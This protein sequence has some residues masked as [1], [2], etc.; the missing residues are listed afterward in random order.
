MTS[1]NPFVPPELQPQPNRW[2]R[3]LFPEVPGVPLRER[4][5]WT[6]KIGLRYV[7]DIVFYTPRALVYGL[8]NSEVELLGDHDFEQRFD[9]T[10]FNKMVVS[11]ESER[12]AAF[13]RQQFPTTMTNSAVRY[14][15]ADFSIFETLETFPGTY[16][17]GTTVLFERDRPGARLK[18]VAIRIK[19]MEL[20]PADGDAWE[21]AKLYALQG[22][23]IRLV[24]GTHALLHFPEDSIN[25]IAKVRL[26]TNHILYQLLIP[27]L[28]LQLSLDNTV[29]TSPTSPLIN[30][31]I[32]WWNPHTGPVRSLMRSVKDIYAGVEDNPAYCTYTYKHPRRSE[33]EK[34]L[35]FLEAYYQTILR[36][37]QKVLAKI[38]PGDEHVMRWADE[39]AQYVPGFPKGDAIFVT[40]DKPGFIR[41]LDWAVATLIWDVSVGH[42]TDHY[43]MGLLDINSNPMRLRVPPPEHREVRFDRRQLAKWSDFF[44]YRLFWKMFLRATTILRLDDVRYP[45]TDPELRRFNDEFLRDLARTAESLKD[46]E[47]IPL[48]DIARSIQF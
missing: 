11:C 48:R 24:F 18:L 22:A 13:A 19:G 16:A 25:A 15:I 26:P 10:V 46:G 20:T 47:F 7:A 4:V 32:F 21:L 42:T 27:H 31:Q 40:P 34:Y 39:V 17:A 45:F 35:I 30:H 14:F 28:D 2:D 37:V 6:F 12:A 43:N 29:L 8:M 5:R 38:E 23:T 41:N 1:P 3:Q 36:F 44:R 9:N 33:E